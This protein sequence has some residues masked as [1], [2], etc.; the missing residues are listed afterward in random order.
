MRKTSE[1]I[2][3]DSCIL[4]SY[5]SK[6]SSEKKK[7]NQLIS[8]LKRINKLRLDIDL[9]ASRWAIAEMMNI[10]TS[11]HGMSNKKVLE[12][13]S[14]LLNGHRIENIKINVVDVGSQDDYDFSE[15]FRDVRK[16]IL[17]YH[18]GVGDAIH[19]V[20]M[21]N[22]KIKKVMTFDDDFNSMDGITV[23]KPNDFIQQKT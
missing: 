4:I 18:P 5:F 12:I 3:L 13:E 1:K 6:N 14:E 22:H 20:I 23:L 10:L 17:K 11:N 7:K 16:I 8:A 9:F 19:S 15:F 2:Y 21:N